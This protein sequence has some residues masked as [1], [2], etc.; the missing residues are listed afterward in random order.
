MKARSKLFCLVAIL[1]CLSGC[2]SQRDT[3]LKLFGQA[4]ESGEKVAET[5]CDFAKDPKQHDECLAGVHKR[6]E[7]AK[8]AYNTT[9]TV[10]ESFEL[11]CKYYKLAP[12]ELWPLLEKICK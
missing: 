5:S 4:L 3:A 9:K 6:F 1:F 12:E 2:A 11:V 7:D 10:N 8:S